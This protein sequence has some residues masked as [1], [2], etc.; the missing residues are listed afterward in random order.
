MLQGARGE[1][2]LG[3]DCLG[4][5]CVHLHSLFKKI[6]LVAGWRFERPCVNVMVWGGLSMMAHYNVLFFFLA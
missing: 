2:D 5:P 6:A 3:F 4:F 1:G